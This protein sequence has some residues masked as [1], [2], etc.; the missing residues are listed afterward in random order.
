MRTSLQR[1]YDNLEAGADTARNVAAFSVTD[2]RHSIGQTENGV[3]TFREAERICAGN[4]LGL[5]HL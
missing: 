2:L 4:R 3:R 5:V 1:R